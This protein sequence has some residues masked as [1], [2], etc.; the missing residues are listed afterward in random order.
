V[1][2]GVHVP[3]WDSAAADD[4]WTEACGK[5]RWLG[6][7]E[8]LERD[9]RGVSD[10][11]LWKFRSTASQSLVEYTRERLA[12]QLTASGASSEDIERAKHLFDPNALT[13]GFCASFRDLQA[14]EPP[15]SRPRA[16]ASPADQ[17]RATGA[18]HLVWQSPPGG[19]GRASP[20]SRMDP[21]HTTAR[22]SFPCGL[23]ERLRHAPD[24][25]PGAGVDVWINTPRRPWEASGTSGMKVLVNGGINLSELDGW[26]AEA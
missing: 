7:T 17:P 2:N 8:T 22:G 12:R 13:L 23:L 4:L 16:V 20:D 26:W 11:R 1:T 5:E 24:R 6:T 9:I 10:A 3:T 21:F 14:T 19:R 25:A 15:A 18:A